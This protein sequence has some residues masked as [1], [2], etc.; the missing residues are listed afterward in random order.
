M[1]DART[2]CGSLDGVGVLPKT[3]DG[4]TGHCVFFILRFCAIVLLLASLLFAV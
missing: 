2:G 4:H 1:S 3:W